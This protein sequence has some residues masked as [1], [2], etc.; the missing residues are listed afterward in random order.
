[1]C[2]QYTHHVHVQ[3]V[4]RY[5]DSGS[6]NPITFYY[7][8]DDYSCNTIRSPPF[9]TAALNCQGSNGGGFTNIS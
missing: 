9:T 4:S 5:T 3:T 7:S 8:R 2:N 6:G 1:M